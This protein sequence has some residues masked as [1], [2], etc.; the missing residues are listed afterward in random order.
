[1]SNNNQDKTGFTLRAAIIA[2]GLSLFLLTS[3][4]YIAIKLGALPWPIIFSVIVSGGLIKLLSGSKKLNMHEINVAQA[5]ASIG[6]LIAAGI[7]FTVPGILYLNQTRNLHIAWPNP[8]VLGL[9]TSIAGLLGIL[10]SVP[11]KYT[12]IDQEELPYPAGT[13]GA[14]LL[15][16]GKTGGR[17]LFF[18]LMVG[19]AAAIFALFRDLYFPAGFTLAALTSAGLFLT[20]LPLPLAVGGG[21]ILG[22]QAGAS[23]FMGAVIGWVIIIPLLFQTGFA[24][25][26]AKTWVQNLGMGIVLGSGI[27]F[28]ISYIIPR[29]KQIFLPILKSREGFLTLL[30]WLVIMSVAGLWFAGVPLLAALI[31]IIG[32]WIMVA[33]AARMTGETNIDPLEQ[34]GIFIGLVIA[35]IY[36]FAALE[37]TMFA[38]FTIVTFVSVACAVAGDAGHDYKSAAIVGTKFFDIV[39]VDIIAVIFAGFAAPFVLETIH[40]GFAKELFTPVMPAPQAQLVAGSIFGF[41]YPGV[42]AAGF[43]LAFAAELSNR[44]LP[45]RFRNKLLLMP[46]G[47]GLFLGMGLALPIA[48]GALI[49]TYIEK[50]HVYLYHAGLLIAAGVMGGEGIAGFTAGA[51]TTAGVNFKSGAFSLLLIFAVMLLIALIAYLKKTEQLDEFR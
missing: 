4:S 39:K 11:L 25:E 46:M 50:N 24:F 16:L 17:Q 3:S 33:V 15:K 35:F 26:S 22:L 8:W 44:F 43:V 5:G 40:K 21:Y 31:A 32:V 20:I 28:F 51:L 29:M 23:R 10:L 42:F 9:L 47:I 30:P 49:R 12:F 6:G 45:L 27:G 36:K 37:L 1:M 14:E 38:S 2:V 18:I 13:A 41:E 48:V 34:F 7:V 19:S